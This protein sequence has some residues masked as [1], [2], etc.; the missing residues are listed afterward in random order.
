ML[1]TNTVV[2]GCAG[3]LSLWPPPAP[4][5]VEAANTDEVGVAMS[6]CILGLLFAGSIFIMLKGGG[7]RMFSAGRGIPSGG[8]MLGA[9]TIQRKRQRMSV[10]E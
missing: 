10:C 6:G 3:A 4:G 1:P 8:I 7:G 9:V 5:V 2:M